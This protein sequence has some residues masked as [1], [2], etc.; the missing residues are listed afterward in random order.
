MPLEKS[1]Q[2][3]FVYIIS[4][5]NFHNHQRFHK[6]VEIWR[7]L[8]HPY[9][10][11]LYGI[12]YFGDVVSPWMDNGDAIAYFTRHPHA[13]RLKILTEVASGLEYLHRHDVVHGDLRAANVL[14]STS[15]SACISDFGLSDVIEEVLHTDQTANLVRWQAPEL[16]LTMGSATTATDVWSYG[17]V[18]IEIITGEKPYCHRRRDA[19]V[20]QDIIAG[21]LPERPNGAGGTRIP[22]HLWKLIQQ[23]WQREP[24]SRP[25]MTEV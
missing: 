16:A 10:L 13:D 6:E 23:C 9:I 5:S 20:I 11:L 22:D 12:V 24:T 3:L 15:G 7:G 2:F 14:I 4:D 21:T 19:L 17:M 1:A 25:S 18:C 8:Q